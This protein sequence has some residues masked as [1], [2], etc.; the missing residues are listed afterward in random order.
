MLN[1]KCLI[2]SSY[3]RCLGQILIINITPA[4]W[5]PRHL[6]VFWTEPLHLIR[7]RSLVLLANKTKFKLK[8]NKA[9]LWEAQETLLLLLMHSCSNNNNNSRC[10][11]IIS[12][13]ISLVNSNRRLYRIGF[14]EAA[15]KR[16]FRWLHEECP[17]KWCRS[18]VVPWKIHKTYRAQSLLKTITQVISLIAYPNVL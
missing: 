9:E 8:P 5:W 18:L 4:V 6:R 2:N 14:K 16:R 7:A 10:I 13:S 15:V 1:S 12:N 11:W 17:Y 3:S